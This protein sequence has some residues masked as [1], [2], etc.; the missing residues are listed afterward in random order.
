MATSGTLPAAPRQR[1]R[2]LRRLVV[3]AAVGTVTLLLALIWELLPARLDPNRAAQAV[4]LPTAAD[5]PRDT[6][7]GDACAR[8]L[9]GAWVQLS[10]TQ[11]RSDLDLLPLSAT[12][13]R[14]SAD[15]P[16]LVEAHLL[17][18]DDG[19]PERYLHGETEDFATPDY[20]A[21]ARTALAR[22]GPVEL[23]APTGRFSDRL[24]AVPGSQPPLVLVQRYQSMALPLAVALGPSDGV[25]VA[26]RQVQV[27]L[28]VLAVGL[29]GLVG[30]SLRWLSRSQRDYRRELESLNE[31][32]RQD[33]LKL[34]Q[35]SLIQLMGH[36]SGELLHKLSNHSGACLVALDGVAKH[37]KAGRHDLLDEG[38]R[39]AGRAAQHLHDIVERYRPV[40]R[41]EAAREPSLLRDTVTDAMAQVSG[42]AATHNVVMHNAVSAELPAITMDRL[43]LCEVLSNLLH[44]AI[45]VM[46][47]TPLTNR[48]ISVE[49]YL[50]ED[51]GQVQI[52]VRDRGP[53]VPVVLREKVF[54]HGY[55]T[56]RGGS[57]WGLYIC[58]HW[59][60]KLGGRLIVTDNLPRGAD[61]IITLPLT[62]PAVPEESTH[63]PVQPV[64]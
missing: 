59:V 44:N 16:G 52:H 12:A 63:A 21:R 51:A 42:Y 6:V 31:Q 48:L 2:W 23:E 7:A 13:L 37:L 55:S 40:L 29:V 50:D 30:G 8:Q 11:R 15:Q 61:F 56:R 41:D 9:I 27:L 4:A 10:P 20:L 1:I 28:S 45:S 26:V 54:E 46:E 60:E 35:D 38:V 14:C 18:L 58:R 3:A 34:R 5:R 19:Q 43:I 36:R 47:T 32:L 57:G 25:P 64:A 33:A 53:G 62:P 39:I 49:N 24:H 17:R 22:G